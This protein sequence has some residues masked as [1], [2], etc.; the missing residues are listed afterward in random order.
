MGV[1]YFLWA[2]LIRILTPEDENLYNFSAFLTFA[3]ITL[4][5]PI[6]FK[7]KII[8]LGWAVEAAVLLLIGFK[9][10][11]ES[12]KA[13]GLFVFG[14]AVWR[15]FI[16]DSS[17]APNALSI[18]NRTFA[19][20]AFIIV[21][22]Y[23]IAGGIKFLNQAELEEKNEEKVISAKQMV[24]LFIILANFLTVFIGS[25]E[26]GQYFDREIEKIKIE[27]STARQESLK[28]NSSLGKDNYGGNYD[29]G[30]S[31]SN[32]KI[33]RLQNKSSVT[34]SIF[35]L[36][37]GIILMAIGIVGKYKGLRV[38][39]MILLLLAIF[40][41]FFYDLWSLGTLYRIISSISLGVVLLGISFSYQKYK[42]KIREII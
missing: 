40:K 11:R 15:L 20:F 5:I 12:L 23:A 30:Y 42:D 37:Y 36:V 21:L 29:Y 18:F 34:L 22:A 13:F 8:T 26:I 24:A 9:V 32:E 28:Y 19:I 31:Q 14:M 17:Y 7:Q 3:F 2:Y 25:R 10:K 16:I 33:R 4:A 1:Y 27:D 35:W 6:Q 38:G 39:G 41:L